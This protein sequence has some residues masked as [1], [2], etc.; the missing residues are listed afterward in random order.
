[1]NHAEYLHGRIKPLIGAKIVGIKELLHTDDRAGLGYGEGELILV[2]EKD[3]QE[4]EIGI[5]SDAEGNGN[6]WLDLPI[7]T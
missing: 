2:V 3:G 6:G 5:W 7:P 4:I 1:M